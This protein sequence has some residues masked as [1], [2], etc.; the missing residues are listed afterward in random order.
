MVRLR[1]G[2]RV[3]AVEAGPVDGRP[4]VLLPGWGAPVFTYRHQLP[5]LGSAGYR[6]VA[7]D[8]KG[9]GFSDKPTGRGEYTLD[10]MMR[11]VEE[12]LDAV[13]G[14]PAVVVG[15]SMAGRLALELALA[16]HRAVSALVLVSPVG[17]GVVPFIGL[18]QLLTPRLLDPI[19]PYLVR[20]LTVKIALGVAYGRPA[21]V[22]EDTVDEFWAPAQY[23]NFARA[24]R[25]LVHDF[26]WSELPETRLAA[27]DMPTLL[28][29]ATLDRLVRG[30]PRRAVAGLR[31]A[32]VVVIEDA[33][34]AVNDE[35]P[36]PVNAAMLDFL[37]RLDPVGS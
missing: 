4:V 12:I 29:R 26:D 35:R 22:S 10:A 37:R 17:I 7:V 14:R 31:G 23:P 19:A 33:G 34:H 8:L 15:Q 18:A 2:L 30:P 32:E 6:A 16:R 25:A 24:L 20:R 21:R 9:L 27:L 1:S 11:H 13:T 36:E 28:I 3:R 5:A